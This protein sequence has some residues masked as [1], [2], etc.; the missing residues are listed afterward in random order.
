MSESELHETG[1]GRVQ[2][3]MSESELRVAGSGRIQRTMSESELKGAGSWC[4]QSTMSGAHVHVAGSELLALGA[5]Q[6]RSEAQLTGEFKAL[7]MMLIWE[8][9]QFSILGVR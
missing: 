9:S 8:F 1:S 6:H 3:T 4:V 7:C 5:Q 2:R